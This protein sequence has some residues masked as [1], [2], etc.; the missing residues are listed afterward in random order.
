MKNRHAA[1]RDTRER[2]FT[3]L[4]VNPASRVA[5]LRCGPLTGFTFIEVLVALVIVSISLLALIRLH[6]I[7]ISMTDTAEITSQA[8]FLANEKIAET[9]ALGYPEEG[10]N[11]GTVQKN[12]LGLH[13]TTEVADLLPTQLEG[14]DIAGLR[15]IFVDVSWKQGIRRKHLQM[16]TYVADRK[17][18]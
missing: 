16:S 18:P 14:M 11:S 3:P 17:L 13:W 9:L 7:S 4:E 2:A 15:R 8:V 5:Q 6:I 10:T 1:I 12:A